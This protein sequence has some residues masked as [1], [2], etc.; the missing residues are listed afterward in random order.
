MDIKEFAQQLIESNREA[1]ENGQTEYDSELAKSIIEYIENSGEVSAPEIC[2]FQKTR[3]R[4]TAY[5]YNDEAE[6]LDLFYL[7]RCDTLC[8][9]VNNNKIMQAFGYLKQF[10]TEVMNGTIFRSIVDPRDELLEVARLIQS[11]KGNISQLRLYV[12]TD[13]ITD[14]NGVPAPS[15]L[16]DFT[17]EYNVWDMPRVF[18]Q[19][20]IMTGKEKIEID[21]PTEYNTELQCL[22]IEDINPQVDSYLTIIPG[23]TLAEIYKR[24][25]QAL[26][27]KNVRTFL[28]FKGKVNKEIRK[29]LR[30][31]PNMFF[32]Y[33]NGISTT[34]RAI[35]MKDKN[36]RSYI[37]K[38]VDWQ[39]V[40][41][42]Q[43][44][45]A[46]AASL[47][48]RTVE[49]DKVYVPMKISVVRDLEHKNE[50]VSAISKCANS[51]T[52][53]KNSDF[54]AND[55]YLVDLETF[56]RGTWVPNGNVR[57]I[58][59]W[60]FERTRGQYNDQLAQLSG[61]TQKNF[62]I[63]Y[64]KHQK[65][66]KTDIAK[67]EAA[68]EQRP[69]DV[70][71]GAERNY[72]IFV[73]EI[74]KTKPEVTEDYYKQ[75]VAK[76]I[77][78]KEI[79][80]LVKEQQLGGYKSNMN[81]YIMASLSHLTDGKLDLSYIW[82]NQKIHPEVADKIRELIPLVWNQI[83]GATGTGSQSSNVNERTKRQECWNALRMRLAE[84]PR[85][86]E[87][88]IQK[89]TNKG[90]APLNDTQLSRIAEAESIPADV[91]FGISQW[92]RKHSEFAPLDRKSAFNFG[93]LR[94][95][96]RKFANLKQATNALKILEKAVELGF[97]QNE[98]MHDGE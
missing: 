33:N 19:H 60:F 7:L 8:G 59:K 13:G 26:L 81:A 79:D 61:L 58:H 69:Y 93:M 91:W 71:R 32:S 85:F 98:F 2:A 27:E 39:I 45:A 5:D 30:E 97:D 35:E 76:L 77:L 17:L 68:W 37:T 80:K 34:A 75:I 42:G 88:L 24:Y 51:Q 55:P 41:G 18:Q 21:F 46:I 14:P 67:S 54:S 29:T 82:D 38:L 65:F 44:T 25:Q 12:L 1:A 52:T 48:D 64:P 40:N 15:E 16:E 20:R 53:I 56:S 11:T 9:K 90:G 72:D 49:L 95:R 66:T 22:K 73:K 23:T 86:D 83:T 74:K 89:E 50:I 4:I 84:V 57:P 78:F 36:G 63:E 70:C 31:S 10:Y 47:S 28:Q 87:S 92:A 3:A 62:R 96:D 43:T 94:S 6:S